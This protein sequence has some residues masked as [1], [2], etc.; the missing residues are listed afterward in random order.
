MSSHLL[1]HY[2]KDAWTGDYKKSRVYYHGAIVKYNDGLY[3]SIQDKNKG[4]EPK[5]DSKYWCFLE[6]GCQFEEKESSFA[7]IR[8]R[9]KW[10][11][12]NE[13]ASGDLVIYNHVFFVRVSDCSYKTPENSDC[14]EAVQLIG[15]FSSISCPPLNPLKEKTILPIPQEE[16]KQF[17]VVAKSQDDN[18]S[19]PPLIDFGEEKTD[20]KKKDSKDS[21]PILNI[22]TF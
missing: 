11:E 14:W 3:M 2:P 1:C 8:W 12:K 5:K 22:Y 17:V 7:G 13:Y 16:K 6:N 19:P 9:G 10:N 18:L 4:H 20:S 21:N 15:D